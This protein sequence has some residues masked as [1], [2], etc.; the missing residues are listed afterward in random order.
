MWLNLIGSW[1]S[2]GHMSR[3]G[4]M[5][6]NWAAYINELMTKDYSFFIFN[7]NELERERE[8]LSH[9]SSRPWLPLNKLMIFIAN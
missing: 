2:M 4:H 8:E 3:A 1:M 6:P 9:G 7:K 5:S